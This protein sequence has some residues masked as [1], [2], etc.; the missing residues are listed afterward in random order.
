MAVL[1][2]FTLYLSFLSIALAG[3]FSQ[4]GIPNLD[5]LDWTCVVLAFIL[6][7]WLLSGESRD[8]TIDADSHQ[9]AGQSF[10]FRLGKKLNRVLHR[11]K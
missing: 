7:G 8:A 5:W 4:H 9:S 1:T 6:I 10:A 2:N 11:F 3:Y